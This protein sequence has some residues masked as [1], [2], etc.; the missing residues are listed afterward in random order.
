MIFY[1]YYIII[2]LESQI[3]NRNILLQ[4]YHIHCLAILLFVLYEYNPI[5]HYKCLY[6]L[7]QFHLLSNKKYHG[8]KGTAL[9]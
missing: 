6:I 5:H 2:F 3:F 9:F 8:P 4:I 1:I 7:L